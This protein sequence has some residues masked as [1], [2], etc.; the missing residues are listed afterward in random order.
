MKSIN[1]KQALAICLALAAVSLL[2]AGAWLRAGRARAVDMAS[3]VPASALG[4]IEI[5]DW[6]GTLRRLG[7]TDGWRELAPKYGLGEPP[8]LP[9]RLESVAGLV[10]DSESAALLRSQFAL[11][12]TGIEARGDMVK[13]LLALIVETRTGRKALAEILERRLGDLARRTWGRDVRETTEY[14]GTRITAFLSENPERSFFAATIESELILSNSQEAI[15]ACI[16]TRLKRAPS[17]AG[18]FYLGIARAGLGSGDGEIFGFVTGEGVSRLLRFG[19]YLI[20]GQFL[21]ETGVQQTLQDVLADLAARSTDGFTYSAGFEGGRVVERYALLCKPDLTDSLGPIVRVRKSPPEVAALVP[22][23]ATEFTLV[24]VE[25]PGGT[26]AGV[27]TAISARI[28]AG[29]S[30]LLHQFLLGVVEFLPA[31]GARG[32]GE[33]IG[34]F[35]YSWQIEDRVW[36]V[37]F[38]DRGEAERRIGQYLRRAGKTASEESYRGTRMLVASNASAAEAAAIFPSALAIGGRAQ[39][40]KL[41]DAASDGATIGSLTRFSGERIS[42]GGG[43]VIGFSNVRAESEGMM[44]RIATLAGRAFDPEAGRAAADRLPLAASTLSLGQSRLLY[45]TRSTFGPFPMVFSNIYVFIHGIS[46]D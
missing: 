39:L 40:Q 30:F 34:W 12:V 31:A 42:P 22:S 44:S 9:G 38:T 43:A 26:L 23:S 28:G 25:D 4:F 35:N 32:F 2:A 24:N 5:N 7:S 11:A 10:S 21:R 36:L 15:R 45:E 6:P 1:R 46:I 20:S 33:E 14:G 13:P 16:D 37:G 19:T 3:Y 17:M 41:V 18:N 27:E 29:Q 8:W